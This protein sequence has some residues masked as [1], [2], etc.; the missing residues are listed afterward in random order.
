M[1]SHWVLL[2]A[3]VINDKESYMCACMMKINVGTPA[4]HKHGTP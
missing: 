3:T 1:G 4:V 2:L